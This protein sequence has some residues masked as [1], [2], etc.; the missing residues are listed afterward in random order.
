MK[1]IRKLALILIIFALTFAPLYG[2]KGQELTENM[3]TFFDSEIPGIKIQVNATAN[4]QPS[5]NITVVL[6][7]KRLTDVDVVDVEYFNLSIYGFVRGEEKTLMKNIT[8]YDFALSETPR[9]YNFTFIV[10]EQI[11]EATLGEITVTYSVKSGPFE[12]GVDGLVCGFTMTL[13]RNVYLENLETTFENLNDSYWQLNDSYEQ[14]NQTYWELQ[15]NYTALQG[16]ANELGNT[17][18]AM[19]ILAVTTVFFVATTLYLVMR[20]P[21][22]SW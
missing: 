15:Q 4:V 2:A 19:G 10:P 3:Q 13:V 18:M 12:L 14:L 17:R 20:K 11:W 21:K 22:E 7:M 6:S 16:N 1:N 5:A 8:E 9:S